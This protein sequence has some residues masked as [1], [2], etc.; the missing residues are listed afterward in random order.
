MAVITHHCSLHD[1][2]QHTTQT[3]GE[4]IARH[5][6]QG[7]SCNLIHDK[8][9]GKTTTSSDR[10][11]RKS[12]IRR[13]RGTRGHQACCGCSGIHAF[14]LY[15]APYRTLFDDLWCTPCVLTIFC[16]T[17]VHFLHT[18]AISRAPFPSLAHP[19]GSSVVTT[20][21][22]SHLSRTPQVQP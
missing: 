6:M 1:V 18:F 4:E 15:R 14:F 3:V 19:A 7:R 20:G 17:F 8:R 16:S 22:S 9:R 21:P 12:T 10:N 5:T 2:P 13:P 11:V